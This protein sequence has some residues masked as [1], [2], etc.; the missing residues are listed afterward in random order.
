MR[1]DENWNGAIEMRGGGDD[2]IFSDCE[3]GSAMRGIEPGS[4]NEHA[5][6]NEQ[7]IE[8]RAWISPE[9]EEGDGHQL[10]AFQSGAAQPDRHYLSEDKHK[11]AHC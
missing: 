7:R 1:L 9:K 4:M 10:F 11:Q 2:R 6:R 5:S 8:E 3:N